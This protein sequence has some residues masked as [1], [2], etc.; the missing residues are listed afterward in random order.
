M[1]GTPHDPGLMMR[2]IELIFQKLRSYDSDYSS[3]VKLAYLEVYN[4]LI[5]DLTVPRSP[6]LDLRE[7][8]HGGVRV[9]GLRTITVTNMVRTAV[10]EN[11]RLAVQGRYSGRRKVE[12]QLRG[13]NLCSERAGPQ[14]R[15]R[16]GPHSRPAASLHHTP[17]LR[18]CFA[19]NM[20]MAG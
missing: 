7:D 18:T 10:E 11:A 3:V 9:A 4:E 13:S 16:T 2:A 17:P 1:L 20:D 12:R 6:V 14:P 5:Y 19:G 8:P 15:C